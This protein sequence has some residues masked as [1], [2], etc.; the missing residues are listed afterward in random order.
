MTEYDQTWLNMTEYNWIWQ[1]WLNMTIYGQ[2]WLHINEY[3]WIWLNMTEY[4]CHFGWNMQKWLVMG[5]IE[6]YTWDFSPWPYS[7]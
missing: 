2:I 1:I 6:R 3:D 7:K 4:D 5:S